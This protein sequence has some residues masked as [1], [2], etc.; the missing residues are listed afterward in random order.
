MDTRADQRM[1]TQID[2]SDEIDLKRLVVAVLD[3]WLLIATVAAV[4]VVAALVLVAFATPTYLATTK[5]LIDTRQ[6]RVLTS[7]DILPGLSVDASVIE[8]QVEL[9]TSSQNAKRVLDELAGREPGP[10]NAE[11]APYTDRQIQ[12]FLSNLSVS[13]IGLTYLI[14]VSYTSPDPELAARTANTIARKYIAGESQSKVNLI[15]RANLWL[16]DR[17]NKLGPEV[18][19]LEEKVHDYRANNSLISLGDQSVTERTVV[20]YIQQLGL[21]RA[22]LAEA[23]AKLALDKERSAAS[24]QSKNDYEIAK[25]KVALMESAI[26]VLT[27]ELLSRKKLAIQLGE[28][29]RETDATKGLYESLIKRQ[30]ETE[31]QQNLQT[32]N[33]RVVQEALPPAYPNWPKKPLVLAVFAAGGI[34]LGVLYVI[35]QVILR[36]SAYTPQ[37][38]R[39]RVGVPCDLIIPFAASKDRARRRKKTAAGPEEPSGTV[40]YAVSNHE[41]NFG[42]KFKSILYKIRQR[43]GT[44]C[45]TV[46]VISP[47]YGDGKTVTASNMA[48]TAGSLGEKVLLIDIT[49][50][51]SLSKKFTNSNPAEQKDVDALSKANQIVDV[52]KGDTKIN[53][54]SWPQ[55]ENSEKLLSDVELQNFIS[56]MHEF[57]SI[58]ILDTAPLTENTDAIRVIQCCDSAIGVVAKAKTPLRDVRSM[59]T[60]WDLLDKTN[61][62]LVMNKTSA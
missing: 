57:Y 25:T 20:D 51:K 50:D 34:L 44:H 2:V 45:T 60:L 36:D 6:Q 14:D 26:G 11:G 3:R 32:I 62:I 31:V 59:I 61:L 15:E 33:A 48:F 12:E 39:K 56:E 52:Q 9:L 22:A 55:R 19:A 24:L 7:E 41:T 21:A 47:K 38:I 40:V 28:L 43:V 10:A 5:I 35:I 49:I 16:Q 54:L 46:A 30:K 42:Q 18:R 8:S 37:D 17:I 58:I 13:R 1:S 4:A 23:E 29:Q 53:F 27:T